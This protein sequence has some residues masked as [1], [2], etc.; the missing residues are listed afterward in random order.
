MAATHATSAGVGG[1]GGFADETGAAMEGAASIWVVM[2]LMVPHPASAWS[3]HS[4]A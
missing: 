2:V 3:L 1:D 4:D